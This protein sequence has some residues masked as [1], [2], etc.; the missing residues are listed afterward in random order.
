MSSNGTLSWRTGGSNE[1]ELA[2]FDRT[3][4]Q[5]ASAFKRPGGLASEAI[6]LSPDDQK[7]AFGVPNDV[8]LY[9]LTRGVPAR[10]TFD[11]GGG[12]VWSPDG[13]QIALSH[14]G[15]VRKSA[16][17]TGAEETLWK[18]SAALMVTDW[19]ADGRFMLVDRTD[20]QTQ[21]DMWL[22]PLGGDRKPV[23]LLRTP[24]NEGRGVFSPGPGPPRWIAYQSAESGSAEVYVMS[25][26]GEPLG[27]WQISNGGGGNPHWRKDGRELFYILPDLQT[28]MAVEIDPGLQFRPGA[29]HM[30]FRLPRP[31]ASEDISSDG[32]RFLFA[33]NGS[34]EP[35]STITVELN[36]QAGLKK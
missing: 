21:A 27:K 20:P 15:I 36:W 28:V 17:G 9:D 10:F 31:A 18:D 14:F 30:L 34:A 33:F 6:R 22:L 13:R 23:L 32:K 16:D 12:P 8:W 26:P 5:I 4:N 3:G 24:A 1:S 2:W 29:P 19:S 25:M 7:I 35:A 11:G